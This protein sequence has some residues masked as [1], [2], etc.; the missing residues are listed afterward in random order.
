MLQPSNHL[1]Q[2]TE[3]PSTFDDAVSKHLGAFVVGQNILV[4]AFTAPCSTVH[5]LQPSNH[6][7]QFAEGPSGFNVDGAVFKHLGALF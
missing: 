3:G 2:S 7:T 4:Q 5:V 6:R 1:T